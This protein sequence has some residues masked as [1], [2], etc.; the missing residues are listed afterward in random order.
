MVILVYR[1]KFNYMENI[2]KNNYKL[3]IAEV[4]NLIAKTKN[5]N[6]PIIAMK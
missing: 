1:R 4:K 2:F 6:I 5:E 3:K